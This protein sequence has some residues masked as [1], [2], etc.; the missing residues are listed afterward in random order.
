M[1]KAWL[2]LLVVSAVVSC[3]DPEKNS[4]AVPVGA[5]VNDKPAA[6]QPIIREEKSR[7]DKVLDSILKLPFIIQ[8]GHQV[9]SVTHHKSGIAFLI[10]S[11]EK[12]WMVQAGYNGPERFETWHR[13]YVNPVTLEMKVY[14]VVN[15]E[16]LGLEDYMKNE[17]Q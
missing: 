10:D 4:A 11:T 7:E 12:E 8:A 9:D 1:K 16:K 14:D 6:K 13:L 2:I 17:K 5:E 3:N 15:D